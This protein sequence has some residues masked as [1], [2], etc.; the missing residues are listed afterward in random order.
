M[1]H[2][3][4][5]RGVCLLFLAF[6]NGWGYV[7][8]A[9]DLANQVQEKSRQ[10]Q[11]R[12]PDWAKSGG[13]ASR[14]GPLGQKL[15]GY[16][17]AKDFEKADAVLDEML[18]ILDGKTP[19]GS[20]TSVQSRLKDKSSRVQNEFPAWVKAGGDDSKVWPLTRELEG[21]MAANRHADAE[22]VLDEILAIIGSS[23]NVSAST[24]STASA[25]ATSQHGIGPATPQKLARI[26]DSAEIIFSR[27]N[28]IYVMDADGGKEVRITSKAGRHIEHVAASF[29]RKYIVMNYF[30]RPGEGGMSSKMVLFDLEKGTEQDL[31]PD[32]RMAGNGGVDWDRDGY[33]YFSGIDRQPYAKPGSR[34][35][36]IANFAAIDVWKVRYDGTG[37][38]RLTST[39]DRGEID[40]SVSEDG[41]MIAYMD[42][43]LDPP[44]DYTEIWVRN[45]DGSNPRMVYKGG[46]PRVT[47]VHDPELSPDNQRVIFSQVDPKFKNFK[48]DANANT[49][50]NI[51]SIAVDGSD[52]KRLS[53]P[54]PISVIPDWKGSK[55]LHLLMTDRESPPFFGI[56]VMDQSGS[57]LR[58]VKKDANIAKWIPSRQ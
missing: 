34:A 16:I 12:F 35:E 3:N 43:Y 50:H 26:S 44:N 52:L 48:N 40:V 49:A 19:A 56:V 36:F 20:G 38:T 29:D 55:I 1:H 24:S 11:S 22:A 15:D 33:I 53:K 46:K 23:S 42:T 54:G 14:I 51:M 45:S 10:V 6:G 18:A 7:A 32:F 21:H 58:R 2:K 4:L 41:T 27:R 13:D 25:P 39:K 37:L 31:V 17:K 5:L 8:S 30:A 57:N 9:A 47:S 28:L